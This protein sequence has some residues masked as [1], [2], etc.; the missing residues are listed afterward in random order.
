MSHLTDSSAWKAL[1][2]HQQEITQQSLRD[3]FASDAQRFERFSGSGTSS[4]IIQKTRCPGTPWH[5]YMRWLN[6]A[7]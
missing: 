5:C 1:Q 6:T 3:L 7:S 2:Q 4:W